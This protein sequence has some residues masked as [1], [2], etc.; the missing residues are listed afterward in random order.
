M[1]LSICRM[2][3]VTGIVT[4]GST[5]EHPAVINR[6]WNE[7]GCGLADQG[8][9][10]MVNATVLPDM[11]PPECRGSIYVFIDKAAAGAW[12]ARQTEALNQA[13]QVSPRPVCGY[14]PARV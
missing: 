5:T 12:I 11:A 13:G 10:G 1:K 14:L 4:N 6:V 3:V 9:V 7:D 8:C 2:I